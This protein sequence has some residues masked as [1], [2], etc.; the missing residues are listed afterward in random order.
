VLTLTQENVDVLMSMLREAPYKN[1]QPI[2]EY[3]KLLAKEQEDKK[4]K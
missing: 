3:F 1:A 4:A 2:I